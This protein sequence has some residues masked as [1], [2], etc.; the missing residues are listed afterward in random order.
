ML[1]GSTMPIISVTRLH[2]RSLRYLPAFAWYTLQA[3][4][5]VRKATGFLGGQ[6]AGDPLSGLWTLTAWADEAAM[7]NFRNAGS[8]RRAMPKLLNW[9]DEASVVHWSQ[10]TAAVPSLAEALRRMQTEGQVSKVSHPSP[11]HA[12]RRIAPGARAPLS[13]PPLR[14]TR[15]RTAG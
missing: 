9:C 6:L 3:A 11:D 12:S 8:H 14:P 15:T 2:L 1:I 7:R 10:D 5:Q 4:R 13:G